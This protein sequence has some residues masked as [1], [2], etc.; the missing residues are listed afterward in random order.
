MEKKQGFLSSLFS[1]LGVNVKKS[2][3]CCGMKI[4]EEDAAP[5]PPKKSG[6]CCGMEIVEEPQALV[7]KE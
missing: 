5:A 4:V 7:T 2:G 1:A 6:G 3:G